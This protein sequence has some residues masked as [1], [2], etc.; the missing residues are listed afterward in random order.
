MLFL[1]FLCL[2]LIWMIS[3][4]LSKKDI[5]S[6]PNAFCMV[7][8]FCILFAI[9]NIEIWNL[10]ISHTTFGVIFLGVLFFCI[11]YYFVFY[12]NYNIDKNKIL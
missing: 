8:I 2:V 11:G 10:E 7:F 6:P 3:F 5:L 4:V 12:F 1:L 9:P